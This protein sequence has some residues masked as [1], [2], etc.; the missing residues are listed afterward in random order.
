MSAARRR[1]SAA[2]PEVPRRFALVV[3]VVLIVVGL[4]G[5]LPNPILGHPGG[6]PFIVTG[7]VQ[8]TL[9]LAAGCVALWVALGLTG[10][11]QG[12][13]LLA[14]GIAWLAFVVCTFVSPTFFGI[15][16][17][18]PWYAVTLPGQLLPLARGLAAV[19]IGIGARMAA[20][21][22]VGDGPGARACAPCRRAG[23]RAP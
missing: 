4:A 18:A 9:H 17:P 20:A 15:L 6:N 8:D 14:F 7:P 21:R 2:D 22:A 3:G 11:G 23:R 16:G 12:S 5:F 13:A 1:A 10:R 19:A